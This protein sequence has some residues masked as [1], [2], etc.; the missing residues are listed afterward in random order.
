MMRR[1]LPLR[2]VSRDAWEFVRRGLWCRCAMAARASEA[3]RLMPAGGGAMGNSCTAASADVGTSS[4]TATVA[5]DVVGSVAWVMS[6]CMG[7]TLVA[8]IGAGV[9]QRAMESWTVMPLIGAIVARSAA[10][11][12]V[13]QLAGGQVMLHGFNYTGRRGAGC[14]GPRRKRA[15]FSKSCGL[16]GCGDVAMVDM[17]RS[18][19]TA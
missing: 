17:P 10:W 18:A 8:V 1:A 7:A 15:A 12:V 14:R 13:R 16:R 5:W 11:V 19:S 9:S 6:W 3:Y 4:G 2:W